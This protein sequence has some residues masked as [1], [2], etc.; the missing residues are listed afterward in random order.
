MKIETK[1]GRLFIDGKEVVFVV[2]NDFSI[3]DFPIEDD[4]E[5]DIE[6]NGGTNSANIHG[7][8]NAIVQNSKNVITGG[9]IITARSF[10]L[11]DG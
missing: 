6:T 2:F 7:N 8:E 4:N 1:N 11:G 3:L 10:R 9:S 5:I